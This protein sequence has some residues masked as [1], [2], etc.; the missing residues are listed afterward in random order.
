MRRRKGGDLALVA[1]DELE[2]LLETA[3]LLRSPRNA[4]RLL[5]ALER[6]RT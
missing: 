5:S 1:A 2:G 4:E 3:H 6:A